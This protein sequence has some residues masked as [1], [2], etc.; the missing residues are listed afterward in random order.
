VQIAR[1]HNLAP[2]AGSVS[3]DSHR[4]RVSAMRAYGDG[5]TEDRFIDNGDGTDQ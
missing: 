2:A 4:L 5:S 3:I 1:K